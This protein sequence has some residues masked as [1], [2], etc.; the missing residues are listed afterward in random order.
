MK[1]SSYEQNN[2]GK[3]F[4]S[5]VVTHKP[6]VCV[7]LGILYGYSTYHLAKALK[8]NKKGHL[9]AYDLFDDYAYK[10]GNKKEV[11]QLIKKKGIY[12]FVTIFKEDAYGVHKKY[13]DNSVHLLHVDINNTAETIKK[14]MKLWDAKIVQK[15]I[16]LFEGGSEKRDKVD[17]MIKYKKSP[18][19]PEIE[20]N[21]I[22]KTRYTYKT[23]QKFPSL[24]ILE[25]K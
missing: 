3:I 15:G 8:Y 23:Y 20:S 13:S 22:I 16:I 18:I 21:Q 6:I 25:K 14:I 24:T 10:H 7:E 19:K 11:E 12:K 2:F 1:R 4:F 17:W 9:D 5:V